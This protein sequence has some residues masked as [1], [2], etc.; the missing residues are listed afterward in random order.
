LEGRL[1]KGTFLGA[2]PTRQ[3]PVQLQTKWY[4]LMCNIYDDPETMDT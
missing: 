3:W 2:P 4:K 1:G